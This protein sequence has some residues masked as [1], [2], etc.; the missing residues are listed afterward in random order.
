M[1]PNVSQWTTVTHGVQQSPT[2]SSREELEWQGYQKCHRRHKYKSGS[3]LESKS[4]TQIQN[5]IPDPSS[6][7]KPKFKSKPSSRPKFKS[8][9]QIQI[10][11][12][13]QTQIQV[14][15]SSLSECRAL[16]GIFSFHATSEYKNG[17]KIL[18]L[19]GWVFSI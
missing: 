10:Q 15:T 12:K 5:Q 7:P 16:P 8:K 3:R 11:T 17:P 2:D 4:K 13:F 1:S 6:N 9:T 19:E 18:Y 14:M